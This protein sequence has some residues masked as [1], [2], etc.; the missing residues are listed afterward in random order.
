MK[1]YKGIING[2]FVLS[3]AL[4]VWINFFEN[5]HIEAAFQLDSNKINRLFETIAIAY[6]TSFIFYLVIVVLKAKQDE[7]VVLP[8]IADCIYSAMNNCM[9][10][11]ASMRSAAGLEDVNFETSIYN[12][13]LDIYPSENDLK[14]ICSNVNPNEVINE[15]VGLVGLTTI[16][17][18]FGEMINYIHRSDY[19]L[20]IVLEKSRFLDTELLRLLTDIQT[21]S[22]HQRIMSYDKSLV[23]TAKHRHDT[24]EVFEK[25][26]E[27][28][29]ALW[30]KLERYCAV[31]LKKHVERK[32]LRYRK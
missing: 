19:H 22:F 6:L 9:F 25:P 29:F 3:L 31:K 18:F 30:L 4:V 21:H 2:L 26:L 8:F 27:S 15:D 20:R 11:C 5:Y 24:M 10:L 12:R 16:P 23:L 7:K 14:L 28:Y 17:H 13:S 1:L 32:S